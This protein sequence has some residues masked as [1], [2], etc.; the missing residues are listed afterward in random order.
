[1]SLGKIIAARANHERAL[2]VTLNQALDWIA[3][4]IP[5]L[6]N[7]EFELAFPVSHSALCIEERSFLSS[8]ETAKIELVAHLIKGSIVAYGLLP[9]D[10]RINKCD[11]ISPKPC[12][13]EAT[14]WEPYSN[15]HR[16]QTASKS[17]L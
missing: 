5:P 2:T 9:P 4:K 3:F 12:T 15:V 14:A 13:V 17:H 7:Y 10:K 6:A 16:T 8:I 11:F 1:M